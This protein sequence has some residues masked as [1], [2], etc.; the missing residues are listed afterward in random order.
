M[1]R[2]SPVAPSP[3]RPSPARTQD[4]G[5]PAPYPDRMRRT[6][7]AALLTAVL[8]GPTPAGAA[9]AGPAA[10][11]AASAVKAT[12][13]AREA[14]GRNAFKVDEC[15]R[16]SPSSRRRRWPRPARSSTRTSARS[17]TPATWSASGENVATATR[18]AARWSTR[19]G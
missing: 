11:Y 4:R 13:K 18:P 16:G 17:W 2:L 14:N 15:L 6:P 19:A 10:D 9:V 1:V 8:L 3:R 5:E 12:N 7:L